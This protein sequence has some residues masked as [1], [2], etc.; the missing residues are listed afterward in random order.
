M[1]LL[2]SIRDPGPTPDIHTA[3]AVPAI[4]SP[5]APSA[6]L[7]SSL[8]TRAYVGI[9]AS[10]AG[11]ILIF[12]GGVATLPGLGLLTAGLVANIAVPK[13]L[14]QLRDARSKTDSSWRSIDDA[15]RKQPGNSRFLQLKAEVN[16]RITALADLP[17]EEKRQINV[18]EN[19]KRAA[20]LHRYLDRFLIANAKIKKIGSG[21]KAVLA[22]FGIETAADINESKILAIQG[23]GAGLVAELMAWRQG[24][25]N[26]FVYNAN[27]PINRSDLLALKTRLATKKVELER[28]IRTLAGSLQQDSASSLG[29][30]ARLTT[31]ANQALA[32]RK[33]AE[34]NEQ[35]A[36]G[37]LHK[38]SKFIS[39]C[40]AALA[41]IGL[42]VGD[43]S[44]KSRPPKDKPAVGRAVTET[45]T[46][47]A[48]RLS[49]ATVNV[50]P[51]PPAEPRSGPA[52]ID[53]ET[54][55]REAPALTASPPNQPKEA[56]RSPIAAQ[57][58]A[59]NNN[60]ENKSAVRSPLQ[61]QQ[62][63]IEL[64]YMSGGADGKW[65]PQSKRALLE[66]ERQAGLKPEEALDA[67]TEQSLFAANA[68]RSARHLLFVGGWSLEPGRCG[69]PSHLPPV[70]ITATRAETSGGFCIFN[71]IQPDGNAAWRIE[72]SC[73]AV[74]GVAHLAHIRLAV[75]GSILQWSA[76][77]GRTH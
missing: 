31:L 69:D 13:E 12:F 57:E 48:N 32:A 25:A 38:A 30:R 5:A 41:A 63:L 29:Q 34:A 39:L 61:I 46:V 2:R 26:R 18:L 52:P 8:K 42:L 21:R 65:G 72:A 68:S 4:T 27:E 53:L 59:G 10:A 1:A 76:L 20:Q 14:K 11:A 9:G 37:P 15:W 24:L 54:S 45:P 62:R 28:A 70:R 50:P 67:E 58:S 74:G 73:S 6:A 36:T 66:Y 16:T 51:A 7:I 22:S 17:N 55:K 75:S 49:T 71:S 77:S 33:Q 44:M 3:I 64:G 19:N 43:G 35:A 40:C 47:S 60:A 56:S 23:F